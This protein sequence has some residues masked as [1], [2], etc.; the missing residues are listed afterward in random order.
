M[1]ARPFRC[2]HTTVDEARTVWVDVGDQQPPRRVVRTAHELPKRRRRAIEEAMAAHEPEDHPEWDRSAEWDDIRFMRKRIQMGT[3]R[4]VH[5]PLLPVSM[6]DTWPIPVTVLH[7]ARPGPTIN[8]LGAIHGDE[9]TGPSACTH[10]LSTR[11]TEPGAPLDPKR[12]AGTVRI[13]P[14]VNLPGFREKSRYLPDGRDLNRAFPG[15]PLSNTTRRVAHQLWTNLLED[16]DA[17]IDFHTAAKGRSNMPQLRV[18]LAHPASYLLAKA[19]GAEIVLDS[20]P[21]S[22]SL[23]RIANDEGIPCITFEGGAAD[24]LDNRSV[25]VA[26]NGALNALRSLKM[27]PGRPTRPAFRLLA[28]GSRW[29]R[30]SEGGLL[31]VFV[32]EGAVM[33]EG[34]VVATIA[35]PAAPGLSVDIVAPEDG[36]M[37]SIA[38]NPFVT[39]GMPV[40]H[41]LP[42][43]KHVDLVLRHVD[44]DG[45]LR[46][47]AAQGDPLWREE[48]DVEE[49]TVEHS[50][51]ED[52]EW[53]DAIFDLEQEE[54]DE[55][56]GVGRAKREDQAA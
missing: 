27:V 14:V 15:S 16:T 38:T 17:I 53:V 39:A 34:D 20:K 42:L 11:F 31:D 22:G 4:T 3:M 32:R 25:M 30:A 49:V 45:S 13:V 12:L 52:A 2:A 19:F 7:G 5:M 36:L 43:A 48:Q 6:G 23:R 46:L 9:L 24:T 44:E 51:S 56:D 10:L 35:D 47:N 18:D 55:A 29:L 50:S 21:P 41:F 1:A 26:V 33:K 8:I 37:I 54:K 40:G 28:S